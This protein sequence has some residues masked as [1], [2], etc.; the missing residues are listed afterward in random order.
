MLTT[1]LIRRNIRQGVVVT[2]CNY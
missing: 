2:R 1:L